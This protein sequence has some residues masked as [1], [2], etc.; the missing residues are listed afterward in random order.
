MERDADQDVGLWFTDKSR[1]MLRPSVW[2]DLIKIS[3][4]VSQ[5]SCH[6]LASGGFLIGYN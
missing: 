5:L 4:K 3:E 6:V 1:L 2:I